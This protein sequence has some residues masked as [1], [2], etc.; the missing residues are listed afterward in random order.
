MTETLTITHARWPEFRSRLTTALEAPGGRCL[1]RGIV[2][3]PDVLRA[4]GLDVGGSLEAIRATR[5]TEGSYPRCDCQALRLDV[6][7]SGRC[8]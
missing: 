7:G 3:A 1:C 2:S 6:P 5:T 8:A 4:M